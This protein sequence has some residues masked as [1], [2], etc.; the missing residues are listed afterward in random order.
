M[1]HIFL[2]PAL[3]LNFDIMKTLADLRAKF[4]DIQNDLPNILKDVATTVSLS[5]KALAERTIKDKGF[6][7][8][9]SNTKVPAWFMD[10]KELN[11]SGSAF[12]ARKKKSKD[13]ADRLTNWGEFREAQGLQSGHVDL[14]Y[15][16]EMWSGMF[17]QEAYQNGTLFIAPLGHNNSAGQKKM[18]WNRDRYGDFIGKVLRGDNFDKM[19]EIAIDET[20]RLILSRH[21]L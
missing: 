9:Y 20:L 16:N 10:G 7:E 1:T 13:K 12:I 5:G 8:R 11:A 4:Q 3:F 14:S 15:A 2:K 18:N 17:P 21:N 19:V 6:G